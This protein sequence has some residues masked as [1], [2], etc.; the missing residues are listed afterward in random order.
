MRDI[1]NPWHGCIK[2]SEGC[3]HC[4]MYTLDKQRGQDGRNIFKV[5]NNFDYP[6]Q[7]YKDGRYKVQSGT[8]LRVCLT[9]DFFLQEADFWRQEAWNIISR[10]PDVV[11]MLL[12]KRPE[13]VNLCLPNN[14]GDGW[15][16]VFFNVTVE[17]QKRADERIP[18]LLDLPFK[19]KGLVVAPFIGPISIKNYLKANQ[20]NHVIA[21]GENYEGARPLHYDWVKAL[22]QECRDAN[23]RFCFFET[24]TKFIKDGKCYTIPSKHTQSIMAYRS[25]LQ[26]EGS[27]QPFNLF[28]KQ[29]ELFDTP[30]PSTC[31]TC[32]W[33]LICNG[34]LKCKKYPQNKETLDFPS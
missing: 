26:Y 16:H 14:W 7:K 11:F 32:S 28:P 10:R 19:R 4:Y 6:L 1:W 2:K 25:G 5:K 27:F 9:S 12:T 17:N 8:M 29:T 22:Y 33:Q 13:R 20:I 30:K 31:K 34:Q 15:E 24:G 18:I 3:E 23:V 21:G